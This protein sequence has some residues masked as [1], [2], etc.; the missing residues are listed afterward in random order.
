MSNYQWNTTQ[1]SQVLLSTHAVI[2]HQ[3]LT[4]STCTLKLTANLIPNL[5]GGGGGGG[6]CVNINKLKQLDN[7]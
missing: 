1:D 5:G 2:L 4:T 7:I 6:D 3:T